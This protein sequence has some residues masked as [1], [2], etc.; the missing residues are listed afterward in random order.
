VLD[1]DPL[2]R[3]IAVNEGVTT[4]SILTIKMKI[5]V[6]ATLANVFSGVGLADSAVASRSTVTTEGAKTLIAKAEAKA[7][8]LHRAVNIAVV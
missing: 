1:W 8:S 7:Q 2:F 3:I 6:W 4:V 5:V